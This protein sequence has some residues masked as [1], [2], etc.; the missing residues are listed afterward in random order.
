M[1]LFRATTNE[2][3]KSPQAQAGHG[4]EQRSDWES[5][6]PARA[7]A[8]VP[9]RTNASR[10]EPEG[11]WSSNLARTPAF[12]GSW[13]RTE[14]SSCPVP[15]S[16]CARAQPTCEQNHTRERGHGRNQQET[17]KDQPPARPRHLRHIR[18]IRHQP[19]G[20]E[21]RPPCSRSAGRRGGRARC[22]ARADVW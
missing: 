19:G 3:A 12:P 4:P 17:S 20:A 14:Y 18:H 5:K 1:R 16:T 9:T 7:I 2:F 15:S 8:G 6:L 22:G 10:L 11:R 13:R 21:R